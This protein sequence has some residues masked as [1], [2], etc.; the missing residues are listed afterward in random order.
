MCSLNTWRSNT[1]NKIL[2]TVDYDRKVH[3]SFQQ[4]NFS[5]AY[6]AP[7]LW[8]D[9]PLELRLSDSLSTFRKKLETHLFAPIYLLGYRVLFTDSVMMTFIFSMATCLLLWL[10]RQRKIKRLKNHWIE[11]NWTRV[12]WTTT[13]CQI[14]MTGK[15]IFEMASHGR[16]VISCD[17]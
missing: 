13:L 17:V 10:V 12:S 2:Y 9:F 4:L 7:R 5:F 8:K 11:L 1:D 14:T 16:M 15:N 3:T 6:S